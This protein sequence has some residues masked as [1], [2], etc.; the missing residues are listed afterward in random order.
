[1]STCDLLVVGAGPAGHSAATAYRAAGGTGAVLFLA[2]EGRAPYERP[3]L[4]KEL[5]R[6]ELEPHALALA[7]H[8]AYYDEHEIT[9]RH[10]TARSLH[11]D[12]GRVRLADGA[13]EITYERCILATGAQPVRPPIPG[14]E[15]DGVHLLRTVADAL[16]LRDAAAP[17]SRVLV[18]GSGFIGCEAAASLRLRGCDVT[19]VSQEPAPQAARLGDEVA[20]APRGLACRRRRRCPGTSASSP[21]I[22]SDL[23][24]DPLRR[25][26][27]R[28]RPHPA[29][30]RR[31]S[32]HEPRPPTQ[33]SP[34]PTTARSPS[35]RR[36]RT[37]APRVLACGD[38]CHAEHA[39]A[40]PAAAC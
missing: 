33:A 2:G 13:G 35:T 32:R 12:D 40:H 24:A 6:G 23:R 29:G 17:G 9:V 30:R 39:I 4:S 26:D 34:S 7:E 27:R 37:S 18:L 15:R 3:P 36:M 11:P 38:C 31:R 14:A 20:P 8:A 28:R 5:L 21:A 25:I 22:G 19:L 1:M 16:A 10:D